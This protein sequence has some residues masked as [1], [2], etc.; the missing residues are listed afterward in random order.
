LKATDADLAKTLGVNLLSYKDVLAEGAKLN[1][2]KLESPHADTLYTICYTSGT[3]GMPKG[4]ML[5]HRN[6]VS[7]IGAMEKF[8]KVFKFYDTDVYISYLP[9]AHV[10]ERFMMLACMANSV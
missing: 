10:M 2:T 3:T 1:A 6:F 7:N 9:L 4:V 8:D 5:T